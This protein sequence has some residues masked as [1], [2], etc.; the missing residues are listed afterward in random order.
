MEKADHTCPP[1]FKDRPDTSKRLAQALP[2]QV[3][4]MFYR[5]QIDPG[6]LVP[7]VLVETQNYQQGWPPHPGRVTVTEPRVS[8]M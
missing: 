8:W 7:T 5:P 2:M 3:E 4:A 6:K 1:N